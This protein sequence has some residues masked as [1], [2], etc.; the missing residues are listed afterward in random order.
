M[1]EA[2]FLARYDPGRYPAV[3]LN[4]LV[5]AVDLGV[6]VAAVLFMAFFRMDRLF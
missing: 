2:D 4:W 3:A 1:T 5:F 6:L